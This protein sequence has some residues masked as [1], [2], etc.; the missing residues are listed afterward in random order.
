[1]VTARRIAAHQDTAPPVP[2]PLAIDAICINDF[3]NRTIF[4]RLP[5]HTTGS[6]RIAWSNA[7]AALQLAEESGYPTRGA[8]SLGARFQNNDRIARAV[9]GDLASLKFF[10]PPDP[11]SVY[12]KLIGKPGLYAIVTVD[13]A[14]GYFMNCKFLHR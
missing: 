5:D 14:F 10:F 8:P 12:S 6:Q 1:M 11:S 2:S 4:V 13:R 7:F 9:P 3:A